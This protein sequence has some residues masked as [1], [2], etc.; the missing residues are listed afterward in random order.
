M[1]PIRLTM[2]A[3]GPYAGREIVDFTVAMDAGIFGIYGDTGAGKT[4]I[5][6]GISFALFGESSGAERSAEDMISHHAG[7]TALTE[8]ELVFELGEERYVIHRVPSQ[9]RAANRGAGTAHQPHEAYLFKA[10]GMALDEIT[11]DHRGA[12]LA[13]KKVKAVDG[14]IEELL[15]YNAAQ[16]RQIV[17]LPQGDFRKILTASSDERSPILKRLFDVQLYEGFVER[18]KRQAANLRQEIHDERLKRETLLN[19]ETEDA[20]RADTAKDKAAI[21]AINGRIESLETTLADHREALA[22][23]EA[24]SQKFSD[25]EDAKRD[26]TTLEG[27]GQQIENLRA[28]S[29]RA[30]IAATLMPLEKAEAGARSNHTDAATAYAA[31]E[32]KLAA[33]DTARTAARN[34]LSRATENAPRREAADRKVQEL[35]RWKTTL[36]QTSELKNDLTEKTDAVAGANNQALAAKQAADDAGEQLGA[37]RALQKLQPGHDKALSDAAAQLVDLQREAEVLGDYEKA[38][39]RRDQQKEKVG[40]LAEAHQ[41]TAAHL[42]SCTATFA[43]AEQDLT[44]IQALHVARKLRDNEPC[45]ACGST[46]HPAPAT[47]DSSRQGRH[48]AFDTAQKALEL[49][50]A[51]EQ[52]ARSA[53]RSAEDL[54]EDRER[55]LADH[56]APARSRETLLPLLAA[57]AEKKAALD[58]DDRFA[59]LADRLNEAETTASD[60]VRFHEE[61]KQA[62]LDSKAEMSTVQTKLDAMLREVPVAYREANHLTDALGAAVAERDELAK[63]HQAALDADKETAVALAA[64]S[65]GRIGAETALA[66]A[67]DILEDAGSTLANGLANAGLSA[68]LF[69]SAKTDLDQVDELETAVKDHEQ[70]LAANTDRLKRLEAE[71]GERE[72]PDMDGLKEKVSGFATELETNQNERTRLQTELN[73]KAAVLQSVEKISEKIASLEERYAPLGEIANLVNGNNDRKVRLPDF[74]IAAMFDEVLVAANLRLGP[75]SS[76]RYQLHRPEEVSGG[77]SKRGLDIAVH[78]ANTEKSRSTRTMSGGEGFQAS[79]ALALGLSDVVQQNSGGIRLDAIFIDEGFGT[80]DDETLNIALET[81][82]SLTNEMRAVGLISHTEQVKTL[83]TAGFDVEVTPT[84]SH[85]H[86]RTEA[87]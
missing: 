34:A 54:L 2:T 21:D 5:F 79:L 71:I 6:D 1:R 39:T 59:N 40:A 29:K 68:E 17:L 85:I 74:A 11:P 14:M 72:H 25:L 77:V 60:A 61:A 47:G 18:I 22:A 62:L 52:E 80:L 24:L 57:A 81:L 58:A 84:G 53:L 33:A 83:I 46:H 13:E 38:V 51:A 48:E 66:R 82:Y 37:L 63:M 30:R 78:D 3:F 16:F 45:P 87:H 73:R 64:A 12:V 67:R 56:S 41:R 31:A 10:T 76:N 50:K 43:S 36:D 75:M 8:V 7:A 19:H 4:T 70:S 15:G 20:F 9:T 28:R 65:E 27:R 23:A 35:D 42:Q 69:Q 32:D 44:D 86:S 55:A 49:A 26:K